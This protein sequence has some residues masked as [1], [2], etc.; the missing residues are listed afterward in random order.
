MDIASTVISSSTS[1]AEDISSNPPPHIQRC[2]EELRSLGVTISRHKLYK[3]I[4]KAYSPK[5][6][7]LLFYRNVFNFFVVTEEEMYWVSIRSV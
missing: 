5:V 6:G 2:I 1:L 7:N 4:V 3:E